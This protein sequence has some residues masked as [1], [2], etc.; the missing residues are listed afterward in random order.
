MLSAIE[1]QACAKLHAVALHL[2]LSLGKLATLKVCRFMSV[3]TP[4]V[5]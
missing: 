5:D 3:L 1:A 4:L 2:I